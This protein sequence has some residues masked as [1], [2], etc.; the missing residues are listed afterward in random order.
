MSFRVVYATVRVMTAG[1]PN[2]NHREKHAAWNGG[3]RT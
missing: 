2:E 1:R 3:M